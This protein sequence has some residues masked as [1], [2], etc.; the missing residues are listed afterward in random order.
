MRPIGGSQIGDITS[1][2]GDNGAI[3]RTEP[4][5]DNTTNSECCCESVEHSHSN[6]PFRFLEEGGGDSSAVTLFYEMEPGAS[7][8]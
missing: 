7:K 5:G 3:I 6:S 4:L 8:R 2:E 1:S